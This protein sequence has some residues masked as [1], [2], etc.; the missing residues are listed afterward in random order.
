MLLNVLFSFLFLQSILATSSKVVQN[1]SDQQS[2]DLKL[3][4]KLKSTDTKVGGGYF[5]LNTAHFRK[6]SLVEH[7]NRNFHLFVLFNAVDAE[8]GCP[9]CRYFFI[10]F[11]FSFYL[12][13][14]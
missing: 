1:S 7:P 9:V 5:E 13:L 10:L 4:E 6:F 2:F 14:T 8:T 3:L 12:T 11:F